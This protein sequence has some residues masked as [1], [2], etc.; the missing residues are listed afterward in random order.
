MST[1]LSDDSDDEY[2]FGSDTLPSASESFSSLANSPEGPKHM[3]PTRRR[4]SSSLVNAL[5]SPVKVARN[6]IAPNPISTSSIRRSSRILR[7]PRSKEGIEK[8]ARNSTGKKRWQREFN[9]PPNTTLDQA[10]AVMLC[11]ELEMIDI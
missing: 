7:S 11:H 4:I 9:F 6:S 5:S 2:I 1:H 3:H 8:D 10:M